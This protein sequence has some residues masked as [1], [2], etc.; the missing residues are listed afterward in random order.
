M[1][2]NFAIGSYLVQILAYLEV[3]TSS[4]YFTAIM[5][6]GFAKKEACVHPCLASNNTDQN[7]LF[8]CRRKG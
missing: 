3:I 8:S 1:R 7:E 4:I 5:H 2:I 6:F